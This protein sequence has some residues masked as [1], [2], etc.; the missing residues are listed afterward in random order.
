MSTPNPTWG[1]NFSAMRFNQ[2]TQVAS[3]IQEAET[4]NKRRTLLFRLMRQACTQR[5]RAQTQK[6][7]ESAEAICP[8]TSFWQWRAP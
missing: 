2:R 1:F 6:L 8:L 3:R 4:P 7:V 5:D